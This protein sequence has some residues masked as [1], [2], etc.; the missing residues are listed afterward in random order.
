MQFFG[1]DG[2]RGI[3]GGPP[4]TVDFILKLGWAVG[5]VLTRHINNPNV[6]IGKDTRVSGYMIE[7]ALQAGLSAAGVNVSLL[8]PMPTPAIAYLTRAFRGDLGIVISAS[9]NPFQDNGIKFFSADG[10]KISKTMEQEIEA[11]LEHTINTASSEALGKAK[12]IDDAAGRYIE[13]CKSTIPRRIRLDHLKVVVDC[14]NGATYHIA[15]HVFSELGAKVFTINAEPNGFNINLECGSI[16]PEQLRATVLKTGA[17]VG[18]AFDGDGDRVIMVDE[19]GDLLDGDEILYIIVKELLATHTL[20]G[21]VVG[22]QMSNQGLVVA[23]NNLGISFIRV[24]VGDQHIIK[25]LIGR[26]WTIGGEPSGHIINLAANT[27]ADGIVAALQVLYAMTATQNKLSVLRNSMQK[28]PQFIENI[29]H[30]GHKIDLDDRVI[31]TEVEQVKHYLG[32]GGRVLLRYSGTEPVIR[33]MLEGADLEKTRQ[34][35]TKL[36]SFVNDLVK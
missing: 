14:A 4:I 29:P 30:N 13:Y 28:Y 6:F 11:V 12:R 10:L 19:S 3:V 16:F 22:T 32:D 1:T 23:L 2:I 5:K 20:T 21:G 31:T 26:N 34:Q 35:M 33:L 18:I 8:G 15:P 27:T 7:S 9:H 17:D 36:T 25:E 24:P